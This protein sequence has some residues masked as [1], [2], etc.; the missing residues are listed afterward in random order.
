MN[1]PRPTRIHVFLS[2]FEDIF[3]GVLQ[4]L[5]ASIGPIEVT[6]TAWHPE[7]E[8]KL[9]SSGLRVVEVFRL[10]ETIEYAKVSTGTIDP[11]TLTDLE[12]LVAPRT[13]W[14]MVVAD[15]RFNKGWSRDRALRPVGAVTQSVSSLYE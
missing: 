2:V 7:V 11:L 4:E 12:Q 14:E 9:L 1:P 10:W 6:A 3:I 13:I 15:E 8:A 5:E